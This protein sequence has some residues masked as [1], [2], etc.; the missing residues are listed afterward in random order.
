MSWVPAV[1]PEQASPDVK[2]VYDFLQE[3]CGFIPVGLPT[4][5]TAV[6]SRGRL[7]AN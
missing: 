2:R 1:S 6:W 5:D 7:R 4:G 3:N